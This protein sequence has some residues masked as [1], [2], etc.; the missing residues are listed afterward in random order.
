M[1]FILKSHHRN[2]GDDELLNDIK[3][4]AKALAQTTVTIDMEKVI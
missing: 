4:V 2:I 1:E 3:S